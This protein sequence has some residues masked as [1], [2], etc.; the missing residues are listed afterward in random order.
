MGRTFQNLHLFADMTVLDNVLVGLHP[1]PG[2]GFWSCLLGL[3]NARR[4]EREARAEALR[5]LKFL[6]MEVK[7]AGITILLVEQMATKALA[8]A[9]RAYVLETG[10]ITLEGT[11]QEL[12]GNPKVREA[13][14]G[15]AGHG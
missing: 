14:L 12:L 9:D 3:P 6:Q 7:A 4:E 2:V 5:I 10:H 15:A 11:G 1:H 8:V 13:Y